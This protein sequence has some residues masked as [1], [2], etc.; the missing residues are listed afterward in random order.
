M[1]MQI[2]EHSRWRL[3]SLQIS[4]L[5]K[6]RAQHLQDSGDNPARKPAGLR[7]GI[8]NSHTSAQGMHSSCNMSDI[9]L[10]HW[11]SIVEDCRAS[12][13]GT[14]APCLKGELLPRR[15][16]I[17]KLFLGLLNH[18]LH[19]RCEHCSG[20]WTLQV[21]WSA[22]EEWE[23]LWPQEECG[24]C[25]FLLNFKQHFCECLGDRDI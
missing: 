11:K 22:L 3:G 19:T 13:Q 5:Y 21:Y 10:V 14:M 16:G 15:V 24:A 1:G 7:S 2:I 20:S 8:Q 18:A 12:L 25:P 23:A 6:Y 4:F 17:S 9:A